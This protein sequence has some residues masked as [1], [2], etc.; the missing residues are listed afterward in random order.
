MTGDITHIERPKLPW[1]KYPSLTE[2]GLDSARHATW[3]RTAAMA[4]AKEMGEQRFSLFVC[5]T[6]WSTARAHTTWDESPASCLARY[7]GAHRYMP[8]DQ[9]SE[10]QRELR[11]LAWLAEVHHDEFVARLKDLQDVVDIGQRRKA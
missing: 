6:C 1:R 7:L 9:L 2:C 5:M 8:P 4:K 11:A 10:M 3:G